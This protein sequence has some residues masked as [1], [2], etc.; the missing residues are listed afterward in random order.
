[1]PSSDIKK[2]TE[3]I[4]EM[5]E[6][7]RIKRSGWWNVK[8]TNPESVA[9]HSFRAAIIAY[10]LA[11]LENHTSPEKI[12]FAALMHDAT[13]SRLLDLHKISSKYVEGKREIEEKIS[14]EQQQNSGIYYSLTA[15][16]KIIVKDADLLEMAFTAKEY[17]DAG[18]LQAKLLLD[19]AGKNIQSSSSK[20]IFIE[21]QNKPSTDWFK[22]LV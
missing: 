20:R 21:L 6:L 18:Y 1:M 22:D 14:K 15:E 13:E 12:A 4:F 17:M 9:E 19:E 16:D 10:E 2:I 7:K 8:I 11:L 3:F 5:G